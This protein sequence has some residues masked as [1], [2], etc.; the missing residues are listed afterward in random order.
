M[1]AVRSENMSRFYSNWCPQKIL[2]QLKAIPTINKIQ[3]NF[4]DRGEQQGKNKLPPEKL[5]IIHFKNLNQ[6]YIHQ[7]HI[8]VWIILQWFIWENS[9]S[10]LTLQGWMPHGSGC[11]PQKTETCIVLLFLCKMLYINQ[12]EQKGQ[13]GAQV[14]GSISHCQKLLCPPWVDPGAIKPKPKP[15]PLPPEMLQHFFPAEFTS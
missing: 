7:C 1:R 9:S 14:H 2:Y 13:K 11:H 8:Y 12:D 10:L 3:L 15:E 4:T 5:I 6:T